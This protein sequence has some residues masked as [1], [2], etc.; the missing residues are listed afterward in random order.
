MSLATRIKDVVV[1]RILGVNDT[2]HRIA[3]GVF[4]GIFIAA[5]P[6]FGAQIMLYVA[7]S[8]L[9]RA[10]KVS[11]VA[12]LFVTNPVTVVPIYYAAWWLGAKMLGSTPEGEIPTFPAP[13]RHP[14]DATWAQIGDALLDVGA[15]LWVGSLAMGTVAGGLCYGLT[16]WG[17]LAFRRARAR[18]IADAASKPA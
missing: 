2:P 8:T 5:T 12:P 9:L 16:Y 7:L 13:L 18:A 6:T 4:L 3:W 17:V 15:E 1:Y 11:G 10:N 14:D